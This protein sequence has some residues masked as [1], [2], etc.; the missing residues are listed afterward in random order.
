VSYG[1]INTRQQTRH[2]VQLGRLA[3]YL[4]PQ[5]INIRESCLRMR[6]N[7]AYCIMIGM[8]DECQKVAK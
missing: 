4:L 8:Y 5:E 7:D 2:E 1:P 6:A 3:K